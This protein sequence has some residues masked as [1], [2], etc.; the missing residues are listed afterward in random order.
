MNIYF[1]II[2]FMKYTHRVLAF[3]FCV[4]VPYTKRSFITL[5]GLRYASVINS[6]HYFT[7]QCFERNKEK[8]KALAIILHVH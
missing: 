5:G 4:I 2:Q 3:R 1:I 7:A 8:L 6:K